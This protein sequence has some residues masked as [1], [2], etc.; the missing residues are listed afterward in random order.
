MRS[1]LHVRSSGSVK[2]ISLD[3]EA[4]QSRLVEAAR[5]LKSQDRN[6]VSVWLFGSLARGDYLPG[7]DADL[8]IVLEKIDGPLSARI[9]RFADRFAGVGVPVDLFP[10][11]EAELGEREEDP[12]WAKVLAER[13]RLA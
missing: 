6:V 1:A 10:V 13:E 8:L 2:I 9:D 4:V 11:S 3:V 12:F 7:S 5:S